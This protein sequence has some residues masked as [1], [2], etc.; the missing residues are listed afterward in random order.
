MSA[1]YVS[2]T[3]SSTGDD[4]EPW[5]AIMGVRSSYGGGYNVRGKPQKTPD[6]AIAQARALLRQELE[7]WL[8]VLRRP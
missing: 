2:T 8:D 3:V 6:E 7:G 5:I 4:A 1:K